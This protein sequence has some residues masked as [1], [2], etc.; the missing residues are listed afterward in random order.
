MHYISF[1]HSSVHGYLNCF[2]ILAIVN[3]AAANTRGCIDL[4]EL[5]CG[6]FV[7]VFFENY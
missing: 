7:V 6:F 4:F 5:V 3:N 1:I 2:H